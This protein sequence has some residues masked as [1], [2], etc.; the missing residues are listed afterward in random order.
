MGEFT[1]TIL[2]CGSATPSMRH[3][4]SCQAIEYRG[5]VM[6]VDCGE[7]AQLSMRRNHIKFSRI[8]DVY[9]TH[10]HGDH[11]LGLPGLLSTMSLHE[12][13]GK[14][15]IHI[16]KEGAEL[17]RHI[18]NVVCHETSFE[19]EYCIVEPGKTQVVY[20]DNS[21]RVTAFPLFHRVP[22][23]GYR[24]DEKPKSRHLR[25]DMVK[26]LNIPVSQLHSI[27]NG[28]DYIKPDGEVVPNARLTT[29]ADHSASYAYASDT[30]FD[31]R[32]ADSVQGVDVLYHEATYASELAEQAKERG[33]S[34]PAEAAEIARLADV[35]TLVI[36]HFSK[37][38]M[39]SEPLLAEARKN[40]P[41]TI[42]ADEGMT[43]TLY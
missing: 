40:F 13:G 43:I 5:K 8:T 4:P 17:L 34:T 36:G 3:L 6:L 21:L 24:F 27:K 37:R 15:R 32:V 20:E 35:K 14:V 33:H 38:Y 19:I 22:C 1:V 18:T 31:P 30:M 23:V 26:F 28:A 11:L 7:G 2:G 10:L 16:F 39:D 42:A 29:D 9:I 25:G 41:N 12:K